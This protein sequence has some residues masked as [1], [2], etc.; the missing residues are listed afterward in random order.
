MAKLW[1]ICYEMHLEMT[2]MT[3]HNCMTRKLFM[4]S[5]NCPLIMEK[6]WIIPSQR[7]LQYVTTHRCLNSNDCLVQP[8]TTITEVRIWMIKSYHKEN[9]GVITYPCPFKSQMNYRKHDWPGIQTVWV[10]H[11][12]KQGC[13]RVCPHLIPITDTHHAGNV[14]PAATKTCIE[15][16]SSS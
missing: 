2:I 14:T 11:I 1:G 9:Y 10:P 7:N 6:G 15:Y 12:Y 4:C 13:L 3:E 5:L 8:M 16:Q